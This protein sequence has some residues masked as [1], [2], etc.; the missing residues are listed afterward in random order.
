MGF[1][2]QE[3]RSDRQTST[4]SEEKQVHPEMIGKRPERNSRRPA[5]AA[6]ATG[7]PTRLSAQKR[8]PRKLCVLGSG[9][10]E[11]T[12]KV[13]AEDTWRTKLCALEDN[14]KW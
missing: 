4:G 7:S 3:I 1:L 12:E 13:S 2:I 10:Q 8:S 6:L 5:E 11:Y 14:C 9:R